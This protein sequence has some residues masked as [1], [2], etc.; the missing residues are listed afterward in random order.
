[1]RFSLI[2]NIISALIGGILRIRHFLYYLGI[3][4]STAPNIKTIVVGNLAI[5]GAGKTPFTDFLLNELQSEGTTGFVSRGYGR[6]TKG[7]VEINFA[8][9]ATSIGD[10]PLLIHR[11]HPEVPGV[12]SEKRLIGIQYLES[13]HPHLSRIVLDDAFQHRAL[14]AHT[15]ILLSKFDQPFYKD[16]LWPSGGLRDLISR[17]RTA[18]AVVITN[19]PNNTPPETMLA[20]REEIGQITKA[21][22]FFAQIENLPLAALH[23]N[24]QTQ[25]AIWGG[26]CGIAHPQTFLDQLRKNFNI[27]EEFTWRDHQW[28]GDKEAELLRSKLVTFGGKIEGWI[29]TE[30]DAMRIAHLPHWK[31]IPIYYLPIKTTIYKEDK[32]EWKKWL[33]QHL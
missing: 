9:D 30:K 8:S 21:P 4:K 23:Q 20:I 27:Q 2:R 18:D 1:M 5:G 14:Q 13:K 24:S 25:P 29:T 11:H 17:A 3:F 6:K 33:N 22:V 12:V 32:E 7:L 31:D 15:Y 28:L 26:F 19:T 16:S 10:E